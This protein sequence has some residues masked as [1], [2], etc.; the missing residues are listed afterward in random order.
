MLL[1]CFRGEDELV[2]C[3]LSQGVFTTIIEHVNG[4]RPLDFDRQLALLVVE[5][6]PTAETSLG[7]LSRMVEDVIRPDVND[8]IGNLRFV[9]GR[10]P[11]YA[12]VQIEARAARQDECEERKKK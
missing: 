6:E 4:E 1:K 10:G 7:G 11:Y 12:L 2:D 8:F 5:H 3:V 9:L